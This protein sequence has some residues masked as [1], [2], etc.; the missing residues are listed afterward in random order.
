[1]KTQQRRRHLGKT[2]RGSAQRRSRSRPSPPSAPVLALSFRMTSLVVPFSASE[3]CSCNRNNN[4]NKKFRRRQISWSRPPGGIDESTNRIGQQQQRSTDNDGTWQHLWPSPIG[5]CTVLMTGAGAN[6]IGYPTID[7]DGSSREPQRQVAVKRSNRFSSRQ[8][9][10]ASSSLH[11]LRY[12]LRYRKPVAVDF[13]VSRKAGMRRRTLEYGCFLLAE[14]Y[15]RMYDYDDWNRWFEDV[16]AWVK[17]PTCD[18]MCEY[19]FTQCKEDY[20]PPVIR[21]A[22]VHLRTSALSLHLDLTVRLPSMQPSYFGEIL[23]HKRMRNFTCLKRSLRAVCRQSFY[24]GRNTCR[25]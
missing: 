3:S 8:R 21:Y 22:W 17:L 9:G 11:V 16:G 19:V 1:M 12:N 2:R 5:L 23:F 20:L 6:R 10:V 25:T 15:A 13:T 7:A 24:A 4:R 18:C 14:E